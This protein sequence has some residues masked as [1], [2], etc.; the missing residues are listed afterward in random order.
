M[1]NI[2]LPTSYIWKIMTT[3]KQK[4][5][6]FLFT[7][8]LRGEKTTTCCIC[9]LWFH[10]FIP[11]AKSVKILF[12]HCHIPIRV[13]AP[14]VM[15]LF[16]SDTDCKL[17]AEFT[18][19]HPLFEIATKLPFFTPASNVIW[20]SNYF[21]RNMFEFWWWGQAGRE[22]KASSKNN[23][24]KFVRNVARGPKKNNTKNNV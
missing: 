16:F 14:V 19:P 7:L 20:F 10:V 22:Q 1:K 13:G 6:H 17:P 11:S 15:Q 23:N 3:I 2:R 24:C 21:R 8:H 4:A 12:N 9:P 5:F 18:H